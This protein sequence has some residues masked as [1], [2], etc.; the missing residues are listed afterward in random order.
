M[1]RRPPRS[2]LFPY[3]TLF[4]SQLGALQLGLGQ[5]GKARLAPGTVELR[6]VARRGSWHGNR[7]ERRIDVGRKRAFAPYSFSRQEATRGN[8]DPLKVEGEGAF[9]TRLDV[10]LRFLQA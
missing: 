7:V 8:G 4:R 3:T 6:N 10:L 5:H 9:Q 1:I 2:T